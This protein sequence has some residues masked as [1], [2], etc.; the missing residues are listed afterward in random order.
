MVGLMS[1]PASAQNSTIKI[2]ALIGAVLFSYFAVLQKLG[3]DW[4]T[5][6]NYSHGLLVPFVIAMIVW[7]SWPRLKDWSERGSIWTAVPLI[8]GSMILLLGGTLAAELFTQ[9]ISLAV[10]L[11]GIVLYLFGAR[12][13]NLLAV[14]FV[15]FLL[16]VPIPQIVFNRIA[17]PLQMLA[18]QA[19]VWGIRA[20]DVPALRNGNIIDI[21]P[22]GSTQTIALEVVE[23][24]SGIRSLMTLVTLALILAYFT[25]RDE[26]GP[27][28][29]FQKSDLIR[30][31]FLMV[32][33]VPIAVLTNAARVTGTGIL[34][35]Y[36]GRQATE[37]TW[38]DLSGWLV[39]ASALALLLAA[40]FLLSR[41]LKTS[42][43]TAS[44]NYSSPIKVLKKAS[45]LPLVVALLLTGSTVQ[46]FVNREEVEPHR[47]DLAELPT[48]M[49][50]WRQRG[51]EIKFGEQ[52][53]S[54]L[55]TTD[56]TMREY[57]LEN[58]R[59]AN[60]Y[61]G[62]YASQRTGA[63]YH[64]PQNCLPGAGW[65]MKDPQHVQIATPSGLTFTAQRYVI[66]TGIYKEV[67]IYWYQGRGKIEASEYRDK[68]NTVIDSLFKRRSDGAMVR[69]MTSVGNSEDDAVKAGSD[70]AGR[71][72]DELNPFVPE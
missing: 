7:R 35:Y 61:V 66:E 62:Y 72:A 48:E 13:L 20:V 26:N 60:L 27:Y 23:A 21:L 57:T 1:F 36:Y 59:V 19:A 32:L 5:D 15:L 10:L 47:R 64:S 56:Y 9:R 14:P 49:G 31:G 54:V 29:G 24:C 69:V 53:E 22:R 6:E 40:N 52:V 17:L 67:M 4:W 44:E 71:L 18:S 46:W 11:A 30:A 2:A 33:A 51:G 28:G 43:H 45:V 8:A 34:T 41:L 50:S 42:W 3:R 63:T 25:R 38:H 68:V 16:A 37:G 65:I 12:V 55:R 70:L 39:Y 58:G